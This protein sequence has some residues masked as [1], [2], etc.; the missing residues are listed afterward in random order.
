[1]TPTLGCKEESHNTLRFGLFANQVTN[2]AKVNERMQ[3]LHIFY[4]SLHRYSLHL[5]LAL[6]IWFAWYMCIYN[7]GDEKQKKEVKK[8][9]ASV[10]EVRQMVDDT[11]RDDAER[12]KEVARVH[13]LEKRNKELLA[14]L[15]A[16]VS[17]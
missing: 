11:R 15:E 7:K 5:Y 13:A 12:A 8:L 10:E 17:H 14:L 4:M 16:S 2:V 1:M 9:Q 6:L 3:S